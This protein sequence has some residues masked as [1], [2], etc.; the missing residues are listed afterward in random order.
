MGKIEYRAVMKYFFERQ[1]AYADQRSVGFCVENSTPSFIKVKFWAE[2]FKR[3][4]KSWGDDESS[5]R[6]NTA[7]TDDNITK[8]YQMVLDDHQI[9]GGRDIRG[10]EHVKRTCLSHIKSTVR[11]E[12]AVH[13]LGVAFAHVRPKLC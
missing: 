1:Y 11:H 13:A 3:G 9:K 12:K 6:Q 7:T 10:Y 2:E 8:V 4:R 5:G